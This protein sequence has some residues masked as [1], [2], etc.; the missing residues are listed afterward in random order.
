MRDFTRSGL[1]LLSLLATAA[2]V[3][4]GAV[5]AQADTGMHG[6]MM[7]ADTGMHGGMMKNDMAMGHP[8]MFMKGTK[9]VSGSYTIAEDQGQQVLTFSSDFSIQN[10]PTPFVVLSTTTDLGDAP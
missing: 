2:V 5:Q 8:A 3:P 7:K 6:G 4:A 1:A 9:S 10:S